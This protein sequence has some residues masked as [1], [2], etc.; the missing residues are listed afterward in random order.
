MTGIVRHNKGSARSPLA[1]ILT[2]VHPAFDTRVF[3]KEARTLAAAGY[4]VSLIAQHGEDACQDGVSVQALPLS[5]ARRRRPLLWWTILLRALRA[6]ADVYHIHDPELIPLALLLQT[7]S[8]RPVIYDA[9]EY[10]GDEVRTRLWIPAPLRNAAGWLT[11]RIEKSAARRLAAVVTVNEHMNAGFL[12]VQPRSVAVHNYPPAEYFG[13]PPAGKR[14]L[15]VVYVGVLTRD[16]GIETIYETG[17]LLRGRFPSLRIALAGP[18]DWSGVSAAIPRDEAGWRE[19]AGV[20]FLGTVPQREIPALL[21]RASVGWIPFLATPNNVRSTPNKLLE[22]MAAAL[23]VVASDF[24]YMRAIVSEAACG[25]LVPAAVAA[26]HAEQIA[27][28]IEHPID[29]AVMGTRGRDAVL[30]RYTWASQGKKLVDLYD[31]LRRA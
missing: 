27:W 15:L 23:P 29:A 1:C 19:H 26:A 14:E 10:Y 16:R 8:R 18:I 17:R 7:L 20:H 6:R 3:H 5:P 11:E 24:G 28:M 13:E 12:R 30:A 25:R 2:S 4:R 9:H 21:G 31:E 22:Y